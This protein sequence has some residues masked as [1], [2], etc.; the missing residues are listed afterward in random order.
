MLVV[1]KEKSTCQCRTRE[2]GSLPGSGRSLGEENGNPLQCS[3]QN[4][5]AWGAWQAAVC[6]VTKSWTQLSTWTHTHW[7]LSQLRLQLSVR[8][9]L[10]CLSIYACKLANG[11]LASSL[12]WYLV[13]CSKEQQTCTDS[14]SFFSI[15]S[16]RIMGSIAKVSKCCLVMS[17]SLGP[18]GLFPTR[19]LCPW[20]S[21]DK[22]TGVGCHSLLQEIFP[23]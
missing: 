9:E 1:K 11:H 10:Q 16:A 5:V 22:N 18:H 4:P 17:N 19:L 2:M 6:G 7:T 15:S 3:C 23:T 21:P 20:N 12:S 8:A 13:K 14:L